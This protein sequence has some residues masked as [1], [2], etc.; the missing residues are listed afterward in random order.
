MKQYKYKDFKIDAITNIADNI[1]TKH[2]LKQ[3]K[4]YEDWLAKMICFLGF[5]NGT[6]EELKKLP[7]KEVEPIVKA[8][9]REY[10]IHSYKTY[11]NKEDKLMFNYKT[12]CYVLRRGEIKY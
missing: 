12:T 3:A 1:I 10:E 7:L 4:E 5:F 6:A 8:F 11:E 9:D 2:A